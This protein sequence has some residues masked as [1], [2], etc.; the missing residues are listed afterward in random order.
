MKI[1]KIKIPTNLTLS[2]ICIQKDKFLVIKTDSMS[3]YILIAKDIILNKEKNI[4]LSKIEK[5]EK[6]LIVKYNQLNNLLEDCIRNC[7]A[8]YRKKLLLKGLGFR[9]S[10]YKKSKKIQFKVGFS[11]LISLSIPDNIKIRIKKKKKNIIKI[12]SFDKVLLGN[13]A[14]KIKNIRRP[15]CYKGKGFWYK[16]Q[17]EKLKEIKKK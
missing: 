11:H 15:D 3:K 5:E 8:I 17:K 1:K 14:N 6:D 16:N 2:F 12:E 13:F 9:I 7:N 4:L 10:L